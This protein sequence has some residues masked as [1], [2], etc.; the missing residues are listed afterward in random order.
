MAAETPIKTLTFDTQGLSQPTPNV[1]KWVFTAVLFCSGLW[2]LLAS[3][4]SFLPEHSQFI[5]NKWLLVGN[6]VMRFAIK[7]FRWDYKSE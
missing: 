1:V 7:F 4:F 2:A 5:I 6:T 3:E